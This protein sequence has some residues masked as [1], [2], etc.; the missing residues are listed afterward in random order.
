MANFLFW[1]TNGKPIVNEVA[2]ACLENAV[3]ILILAEFES[4]VEKLLLALNKDSEQVYFEQPFNLSDRLKFV[5]RY[6]VDTVQSLRDGQGFAARLIKPPVGV[7]VLLFAVHLPSKL[8]RSAEEQTLFSVRL[9]QAIREC[10]EQVGHAN[11]LI[12]GDLNMDPF[13]DGM[14]AADGLHGVMDKSLAR[15]GGRTVDGERRPF[16]YNPMWSRLGDETAGPPGTYFYRGGQLSRFWHT[17][18]QIL[19]R[20]S[21]LPYYSASKLKV[22]TKVGDRDL[23]ANGRIDGSVS[24]HL[25][26]LVGLSIEYEESN[27]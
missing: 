14:V 12:I 23:V 17:F 21:I 5:T 13:D 4:G 22:V 19:L 11:S 1:N 24:D 18:D 26:I 16:F 9:S 6:P 7:E 15:T 2:S 8:H 10:E 20:P 27:G 3:D 25:P